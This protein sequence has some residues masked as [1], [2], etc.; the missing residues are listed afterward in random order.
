MRGY[1]GPGKNATEHD[2]R[3]WWLS[4]FSVSFPGAV[5]PLRMLLLLALM[6][7][8]LP[9]QVDYFKLGGDALD[10][11][12]HDD[13][14][15]YYTTYLQ[16]NPSSHAA[17]NNRAL[18]YQ[19]KG[20]YPQA[21][22][23][24]RRAIQLDPK[25][26]LYW[27][28]RGDLYAEK[29]EWTSAAGDFSRAIELKKNNSEALKKRCFAYIMLGELDAGLA[30]ANCVVR[31]CPRDA[32]SYLL[33]GW[34]RVLK[35][36][37]ELARTDLTR[38]IALDSTQAFS[39]VLRG[40]VF[41]E[42]GQSD[43]AVRDASRALR[44]EP[45]NSEALL[46]RGVAHLDLY[47]RKKNTARARGD[48]DSDEFALAFDD[49]NKAVEEDSRSGR[50]RFAR[51]MMS[52]MQGDLDIAWSDLN[53]A[54]KLD[55]SST[56][57]WVTLAKLS[58]RRSDTADA[59]RRC[60]KALAMLSA[61]A[62]SSGY[63]VLRG[64][65]C[66][67]KADIQGAIDYFSKGIEKYGTDCDL[68]EFRGSLYFVTGDTDRAVS[69]W[70][71]AS[72]SD[73]HYPISP[74]ARLVLDSHPAVVIT[75]GAAKLIVAPDTESFDSVDYNVPNAGLRREHGYAL[76]V[77]V[78]GYEDATLKYARRDADWFRNY[79]RQ[80]MGISRI[81]TLFDA[82]ATSSRFRSRLE[83]WLKKKS[84]FKVVFFSGHGCSNPENLK[85]P[86]PYLVP[87]DYDGTPSTL[88]STKDIPDLC[89]SP[90]DTLVLVYDACMAGSGNKAGFV[91]VHVPTTSAVTLA[92]ADSSQPSREFD[93]AQHGYFTYYSLLGLRGKAD[94]EP[95]GNGDGWVT[96]TELYRYVKDKVSDATNEVQVPVLRPERE[97]KLG[98]YR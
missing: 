29:S 94:K 88:I 24:F 53:Q 89:S 82:Q 38:S 48:S 92:A 56:A 55:T 44:I 83:N 51:G 50:A 41:N 79:A 31:L 63:Y 27:R 72:E 40:Q 57:A 47:E 9:A 69:D 43:S 33:R 95:Y 75:G 49:F 70:R 19:R 22:E 74:V 39:W 3:E 77:G 16:S 81:E 17:Y 8:M 10:Q 13:A 59:L 54:A 25:E 14:I 36:D 91:P 35:K 4:T 45:G 52:Y 71:R 87:H 80:V 73:A 34:T 32:P 20:N 42:H 1:P 98:R 6:A 7:A 26:E 86:V 93:K 96:T 61:K 60:E 66:S 85:D 11:Q 84:G 5:T 23:D 64:M 78:S 68:Y 2:G 37:H 15:S 76:V 90:T 30:D 12:R 65:E 97:I 62:I 67:L 18:A 21:L 46:V 58:Y 28:N